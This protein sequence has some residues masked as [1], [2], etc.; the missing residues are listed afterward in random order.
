MMSKEVEEQVNAEIEL[1]EYDGKLVKSYLKKI[2]IRILPAIFLLY[3]ASA[4]DRGNISAAFVNGLVEDLKLSPISQANI[5]T[6]FTAF[7]IAFQVSWSIFAIVQAFAKTSLT[8]TV[9]RC[10]MGVFEAGLTPGIVAY[11]PYWYTKSEVGQRT[12]FF[13]SAFFFS[14]VIGAPMAGGIVSRKIGS[15]KRYEAL[16]LIEGSLTLAI[17]IFMFFMI[18]DY[19]DTA[20]FFTQEEQ[21]LLVRRITASQGLASKTRTSTK[22]TVAAFADWKVYIFSIIAFAINNC[23]IVIGYFGP[24]IFKSMGYNS[25]Q[26]TYMGTLPAAAGFVGALA[27]VY[28]IKKFKLSDLILVN[29]VF[30]TIGFAIFGYAKQNGLRLFG[31]FLHSLFLAGNFS[32]VVTWLSVNC[33]SVPKR[34]VSVAIYSTVNGVA[35]I[36]VPYLFTYNYAPKYVMGFSFSVGLLCLSVVL[37]IFLRLYFSYI[38]KIRLENPVDLSKMSVE[39]QQAMNDN[40][41]NF[42]YM[43]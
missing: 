43:L 40:H 6:L 31:I 23:T 32:L 16:F 34:M 29:L 7:Y 27:S 18:K 38:N 1:S 3:V 36:V 19:P 5:T 8:L 42:I 12:A 11:L 37:T 13:Y 15:L 22:Q 9:F 10:I 30:A 21:E 2:D 39:D 33:G 17:G 24:S 25:S 4:L 26:A 41:P 14:S 28:T 35:G 20:K